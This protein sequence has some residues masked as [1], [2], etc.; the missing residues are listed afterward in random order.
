PRLWGAELAGELPTAA[1]DELTRDEAVF[2]GWLAAVAELGVALLRGVPQRSGAVCEGVGLFGHVRETNYGR[3]F[4][5][6]SVP[7]PLN[8][9][10]TNLGLGVH[11]DN[12]YRDPVPTL[13][14]LHCLI[15]SGEGGDTVLVDGFRAV[16]QLRARSPRALSLL[17]DVPVRYE[18]E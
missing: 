7:D 3:F 17:A 14:L 16:E 10:D 15:A 9:A 4:D 8:L 2:A 1:H 18:Y 13:Q 11:T 12:P 5:V 6:R